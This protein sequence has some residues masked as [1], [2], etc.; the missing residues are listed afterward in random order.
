MSAVR[1]CLRLTEELLV[2]LRDPDTMEREHL[3][4]KIEETLHRRENLLQHIHPPFSSE[5]K[6]SGR[7][8]LELNKELSFLLER[9]HNHILRELNGLELK[10]AS[11]SRYADPYRSASRLDGAFYDKRL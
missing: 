10:K 5:D 4:S 11:A 9:I 3:T 8:L 7:K 6:L 1:E 2:I